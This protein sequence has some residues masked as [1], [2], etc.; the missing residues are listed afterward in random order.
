MHSQLWSDHSMACTYRIQ[1]GDTLNLNDVQET[2]LLAEL[3]AESIHG[4]AAVVLSGMHALDRQSKICEID[5]TAPAGQDL[6]RLF[7]SFLLHEFGEG[8][9]HV[10]RMDK[11]SSSDAQRGR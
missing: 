6:S 5:A 7:I 8:A 4:V 3:A 1:F 10:Q 9:F 11:L 2:L